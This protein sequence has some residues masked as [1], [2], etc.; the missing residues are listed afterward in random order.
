MKA[1]GAIILLLAA[2]LAVL[3]GV[4]VR[5]H[6]VDRQNDVVFESSDGAWTDKTDKFKGRSFFHVL[7]SFEAYKLATSQPELQLV[8]VMGEPLP[9][10]AE[11]AV[12]IGKASGRAQSLILPLPE[13]QKDEIESRAV[14]SLKKWAAEARRN[15]PGP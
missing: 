7:W 1:I 15:P 5:Q 11:S 3:C 14:A 6:A 2:L 9:N 12:P 13:S 8:R 10:S 4:M